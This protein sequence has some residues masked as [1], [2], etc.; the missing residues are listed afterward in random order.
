MIAESPSQGTQG[1]SKDT[2][3][4]RPHVPHLIFLK[5]YYIIYIQNK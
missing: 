2:L 1:A 3:D 4:G 5:K